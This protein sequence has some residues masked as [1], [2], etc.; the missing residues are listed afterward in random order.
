MG[1]LFN[2]RATTKMLAI[3]NDA[4]DTDSQ[5]PPY[6]GTWRESP[7]TGLPAP[8]EYFNA[9]SAYKLPLWK[10]CIDMQIF[11]GN[12]QNSK[13]D[14]RFQKWLKAL[15]KVGVG[16]MICAQIY[17]G[18]LD[19][20]SCA[21]IYFVLVPASTITVAP[22]PTIVGDPGAYTLVIVISTVEVNKV[23]AFVKMYQAMLAS[24]RAA[25]RR[26]NKKKKL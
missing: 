7:A 20:L 5:H 19:D 8:M 1:L 12:G 18:L 10:I 15:D 22:T 9:N 16:D 23:Q 14:K 2:T 17:Q 4:F 3:I 25:I 11:A 24:K 26:A 6:I 21:E 13:E